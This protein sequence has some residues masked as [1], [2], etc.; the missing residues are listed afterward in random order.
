M[1]QIVQN[2]YVGQSSVPLPCHTQVPTLSPIPPKFWGNYVFYLLILCC[3]A[4]TCELIYTQ[5][6][7]TNAL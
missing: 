5:H 4:V 1:A 7:G 2:V 6:K 3:L